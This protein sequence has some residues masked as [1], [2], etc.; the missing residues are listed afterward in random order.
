MMPFPWS[1]QSRGRSCVDRV[2][3]TTSDALSVKPGEQRAEF[4]SSQPCGSPHTS[5]RSFSRVGPATESA[6]EGAMGWGKHFKIRPPNKDDAFPQ[7][8]SRAGGA[9]STVYRIQRAMP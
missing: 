8:V 5:A 3:D 6:A 4:C 2:S 7:G 9:A 1:E